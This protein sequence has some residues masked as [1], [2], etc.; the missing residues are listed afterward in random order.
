MLSQCHIVNPPVCTCMR[1]KIAQLCACIVCVS[2]YSERTIYTCTCNIH[3]HVHV[4]VYNLDGFVF[5]IHQ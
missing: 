5:T 4:H 2:H 1:V 3:V